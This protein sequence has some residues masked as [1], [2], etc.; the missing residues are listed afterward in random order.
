MKKS[1]ILN[2]YWWIAALA[3]LVLVNIIA[4]FVHMRADLTAEKRYTLSPST[5]RML[6]G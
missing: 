1:G 3:A 4:S 6:D 5:R 2:K